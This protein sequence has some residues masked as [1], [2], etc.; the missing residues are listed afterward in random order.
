MFSRIKA[1][2]D[3][4]ST[5]AFEKN[6]T[7]QSLHLATAVLL[8]EVMRADTEITDAEQAAIGNSLKTRFALDEA[9]L[10]ELLSHANHAATAAYDFQRF[11]SSINRQL[12]SA[13]KQEI[14]ETLWLVAF[15]DGV[16]SA[17]ENHLMRKIADLLHISHGDYVAAKASAKDRAGSV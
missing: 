11:T 14:I 3:E 1:L 4:V 15:S 2:F 6:H 9:S 10:S 8:I 7:T 12:N 16:L 17:H 5:G 13:E